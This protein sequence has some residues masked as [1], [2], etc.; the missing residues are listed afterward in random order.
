[1]GVVEQLF[2]KITGEIPHSVIALQDG[3]SNSSYLINSEKVFRLKK[4][5]DS[6]FYSTQAEGKILQLITPNRIGPR[7]FY[8]DYET[9][10]MIDRYIE[11]DHRFLRA[12]VTLEELESLA[13]LLLRLHA[14]KG[15]TTEFYP[16]QRF[17]SYKT[18]SANDLKDP[19]EDKVRAIV[20]G[21]FKQEPLVLCHNDLVHDNVII[22]PESKKITLID[23]EFAGL[24]NPV[25]DLA[26]VLSEN[27]IEDPDKCRYFIKAYYGKDLGENQ[28]KKV[29]LTMLYEDYLWY[30]W[31]LCRFKETRYAPFESIA[32]DKKKHL[33]K[34]KGFLSAHPDYWTLD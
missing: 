15:C 21:F 25:F 11:G 16:E 23:F 34:M 1:M 30:Y 4:M 8:F 5:S 7:L 17:S 29:A 32:E 6:P 14:I 18:R 22:E 9:G 3:F 31:A 20:Y 27:D 10:N 13:K 28:K 2:Q 33:A 24:N 26:S 19:D 12:D